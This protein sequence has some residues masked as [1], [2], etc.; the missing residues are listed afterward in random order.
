[1]SLTPDGDKDISHYVIRTLTL[2]R[3][4]GR[5]SSMTL[6]EWE[7]T[8]DGLITAALPKRVKETNVSSDNL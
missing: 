8:S 7:L 1:M 6:A 5:S 4:R 2:S 3:Y